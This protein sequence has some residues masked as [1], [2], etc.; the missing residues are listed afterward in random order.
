MFENIRSMKQDL[1]FEYAKEVFKR[2]NIEFSKYCTLGISLQNDEM[3]TNLGLLI[4][5][6]CMHTIKV[7]VFSD[8]EK[9]IFVILKNLVD[10][11]S[12]S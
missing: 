11:F 12:N 10:L 3:Y 8:E 7:A 4:S 9:L 2:Y 6:Q 5:D 1:S